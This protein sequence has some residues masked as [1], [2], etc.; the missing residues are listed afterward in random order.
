M[1]NERREA[2]LGRAPRCR[3]LPSSRRSRRTQSVCPEAADPHSLNP[4]V[5]GVRF[6]PR[7]SE[8]KPP[9]AAQMAPAKRNPVRR[10]REERS[11]IGF[12]LGKPV[13]GPGITWP[14]HQ[15]STNGLV[16]GCNDREARSWQAT[17][18]RLFLA[19]R[20]RR[21]ECVAPTVAKD[22]EPDT[23]TIKK[24]MCPGSA[25][26]ACGEA[27]VSDV[28]KDRLGERGLREEG[29][30]R[31]S[32]RESAVNRRVAP[33]DEDRRQVRVLYNQVKDAPRTEAHRGPRVASAPGPSINATSAPARSARICAARTRAGASR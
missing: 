6:Y 14:V 25:P 29:R 15:C 23:R 13:L 8:G 9:C 32:T 4:A 28:R 21:Q 5:A 1:C 24:R 2:G 12:L 31:K 18:S 26:Q 7:T 19:S 16:A 22:K 30:E 20:K 10:Q 17:A 3:T 11:H 33:Q 27:S